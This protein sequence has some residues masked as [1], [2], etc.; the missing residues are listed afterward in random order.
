MLLD[1]K[2]RVHKR[3]VLELELKNN[4][5]NKKNRNEK[6]IRIRKKHT[7]PRVVAIVLL[8]ESAWA[9]SALKMISAIGMR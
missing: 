8:S 1:T 9:D 2:E 6:K 3:Y 4:K 7:N 5:C